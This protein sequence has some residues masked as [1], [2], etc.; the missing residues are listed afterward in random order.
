MATVTFSLIVLRSAEMDRAAR[1]YAL[2]GIEFQ[3]EQHQS[4]PEHLA[5]QVGEA[6]LEI[7]PQVGAADSDS[8]RLGFRVPSV[9]IVMEAVRL[10]GGTVVT[11]PRRSSW[12]YRAVLADPDGRRVE[13]T[14]AEHA[15]PG[16]RA[17]KPLD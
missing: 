8:V 9:E 4:G 2:L 1:F 14:E 3:R 15:Q 6:V 7:D 16:I 10:A 11:L 13:I 5:A 17:D 12:G